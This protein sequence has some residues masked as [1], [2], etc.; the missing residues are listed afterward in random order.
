MSPLAAVRGRLNDA[1]RRFGRPEGAVRLLAVTKSVEPEAAEDLWHAGQRDFGENRL[2]SLRRKVEHFRQRGL[3]AHWHFIGQLQR[4]KVRAVLG[5]AQTLHSIDRLSLLETLERVASEGGHRPRIFLQV[6]LDPIPSDPPRGEEPSQRAGLLP[7]EVPRLWERALACESLEVVGLMAMA[8]RPQQGST[9]GSTPDSTPDSTPEA[10][11]A[12]TPGKAPAATLGSSPCP[13]PPSDP[14][15]AGQT[16]PRRAFARLA[17]LAETLGPLPG[18]GV[19]PQLSMGMS[20]DLED[21]VAEGADWVRIGRALFSRA[22]NDHDGE[23]RAHDAE[24]RGN[25]IA[26]ASRPPAGPRNSPAD[27]S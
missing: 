12:T 21:A 26:K 14:E 15:A 25:P 13:G 20:S 7:E 8:P 24:S 19:P 4:N 2:P 5:L 10:T 3:D 23:D 6:N 18:S 1:C 11:L 9:S 27:P 22:R 17:A 16:G